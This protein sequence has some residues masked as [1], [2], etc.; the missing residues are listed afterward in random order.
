LSIF[1][2]KDFLQDFEAP[3]HSARVS[4]HVLACR[5]FRCMGRSSKINGAVAGL[6]LGHQV[7]LNWRRGK[8]WAW[9]KLKSFGWVDWGYRRLDHHVTQLLGIVHG[10]RGRRT[11]TVEV[12]DPSFSKWLYLSPGFFVC[13]WMRS[14]GSWGFRVQHG[15]WNLATAEHW[16]GSA[17]TPARASHH[18]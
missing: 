13:F 16:P 5:Q 17:G 2:G 6:A 9:A 4:R 14:G 7:M 1:A 15:S 8:W 18:L 3:R 12:L 11:A 10:K